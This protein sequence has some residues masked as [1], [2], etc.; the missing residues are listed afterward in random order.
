MND[1]NLWSSADVDKW[2]EYYKGGGNDHVASM[3]SDPARGHRLKDSGLQGCQLE[4]SRIPRGNLQGVFAFVG[5]HRMAPSSDIRLL[6]H[7]PVL[8][9]Q[10]LRR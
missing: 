5:H 2:D 1:D 6:P 8:R 7:T 10:V 9:R 3:I 4:R